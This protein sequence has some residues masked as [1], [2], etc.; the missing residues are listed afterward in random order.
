MLIANAFVSGDDVAD[1]WLRRLVS[2]GD[3]YRDSK[4]AMMSRD[5][6]QDFICFMS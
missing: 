5:D 1:V 6:V 4:T 3:V 2:A